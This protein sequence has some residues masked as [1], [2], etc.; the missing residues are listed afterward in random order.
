MLI[1]KRRKA[2]RSCDNR[3]M[4]IISY[5]AVLTGIDFSERTAKMRFAPFLT[6][7]R[8]WLL[9]KYLFELKFLHKAVK[10]YDEES[11]F[12]AGFL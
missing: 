12:G 11:Y 7:V 9:S 6:P 5:E 4:T 10:I 3:H 8:A 2:L 1:F